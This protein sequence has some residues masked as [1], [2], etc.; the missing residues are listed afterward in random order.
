MV[1]NS[2]RLYFIAVISI[3]FAFLVG[4]S[5]IGERVVYDSSDHKVE[6]EQTPGRVITTTPST[7]EI[8]F[9]LGLSSAIVGVNSLT[10]YLSYAPNIQSAAE[11]KEKIGRFNISAEKIVSLKPDLVIADLG[12]Q[13]E[14]IKKLRDLEIN[15]YAVGSGDLE[16]IQESVLDLGYLTDKYDRAQDIVARMLFKQFKLEEAVSKLEEKKRVL[17]I[18]DDTIYTTGPD[19][20]L[21]NILEM[22]GLSNIFSD[23][24]GY[25]K[26]S[27]EVIIERN[28]EVIVSGP[29]EIVGLTE[30]KLK[31]RA[32]FNNIKAVKDGNIV[33]LTEEDNSMISQP[34]TMVVDGAISLFEKVYDK[35]LNIK[36]QSRF[37]E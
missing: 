5:A 16:D 35:K 21:G 9:D 24:S 36:Y 30:Q 23:I 32:G 13:M 1:S 17:Y 2:K 7:T 4:Y 12:T 11:E 33:F 20:F 29:Q 10:Q 14:L 18:I 25:K 19:T 31:N 27:D 15:V 26:V 34:A 3:I 8:G 28:P 37:K 22:A 6:L